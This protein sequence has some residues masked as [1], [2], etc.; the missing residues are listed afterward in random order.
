MDTQGG[1]APLVAGCKGVPPSLGPLHVGKEEPVHETILL[2]SDSILGA[3]LE[4]RATEEPV[5]PTPAQLLQPPPPP[6]G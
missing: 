4:T 2:K 6:P 5:I 3:E 1:L